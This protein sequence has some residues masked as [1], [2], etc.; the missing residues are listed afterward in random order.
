M[1]KEDL[2]LFNLADGADLSPSS[3][4]LDGNIFSAFQG[5]DTGFRGDLCKVVYIKGRVSR[6]Q[7]QPH[8]HAL[9]ASGA[10]IYV[11]DAFRLTDAGRMSPAYNLLTTHVSNPKIRHYEEE[12]WKGITRLLGKFM[13]IQEAR[14]SRLHGVYCNDYIERSIERDVVEY[15]RATDRRDDGTLLVVH[16]DAGVGKSTLATAIAKRMVDAS[17]RVRRIPIFLPADEWNGNRPQNL[18]EILDDMDFPKL[19][20]P[21]FHRLLQQGYLVLVFDG[22]DELRDPE[23]TAVQRL[24]DLATIAQT[25]AR[26]VV[27]VRPSFWDREISATGVGVRSAPVGVRIVHLEP[28]D[29]DDRI[30]YWTKRLGS[31]RVPEATRIYGNYV[32]PARATPVKLFQLPE[33]AAMIAR[34]VESSATGTPV[35]GVPAGADAVD[36]FLD[37]VINRER[38]RQ[39]I[40]TDTAVLKAA[41]QEL[42]MSHPDQYQFEGEELLALD[43]VPSDLDHMRDHALLDFSKGAGYKFR[44]AVVPQ[45]FR[46]AG[47]LSGILDGEFTPRVPLHYSGLLERERDGSGDFVV[48]VAKLMSVGQAK[49]FGVVHRD[50]A[51]ENLKSLLFHI[52]AEFVSAQGG[53]RADQWLALVK[54]LGG[55]RESIDGLWVHGAVGPYNIRDFVIRDSKFTNLLLKGNLA[56]LEFRNCE[57]VGS[58]DI[59]SPGCNF[60][61][62]RVAQAHTG[63]DGV[64]TAT[65]RVAVAAGGTSPVLHAEDLKRVLEGFVGRFVVPGRGYRGLS[66]HDWEDT[67]VRTI[68]KAFG[69]RKGFRSYGI[70]DDDDQLTND[71]KIWVGRLLTQGAYDGG[72]RSVLL[73]MERT[74]KESAMLREDI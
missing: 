74:A 24:N 55:R 34:I 28:F 33:C 52:L 8:L 72:V 9:V 62:C 29:R 58:L 40:K 1:E 56:G 19:E 43:V 3:L 17:R 14:V 39:N 20:K 53:T 46:A 42:A 32:R 66:N 7:L 59:T 61:E 23:L 65:T 45:H 37:F 35:I 47:F 38:T 60:G 71:G 26:I 30:R 16:A 6:P 2:R 54:L 49:Q 27:T 10:T 22:F 12:M 36:S 63:T 48:D 70:V 57:F 21:V 67:S 64:I 44:Y 13:N 4:G 69:I 41:F 50:A 25:D 11:P 15:V 68:N 73:G 51:N 5:W 31:A 18:D